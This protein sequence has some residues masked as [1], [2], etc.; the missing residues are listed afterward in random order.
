MSDEDL[1][2]QGYKIYLLKNIESVHVETVKT[3][4]RTRDKNTIGNEINN[5]LNKITDYSNNF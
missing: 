3:M 4:D 5:D 1:D 2:N